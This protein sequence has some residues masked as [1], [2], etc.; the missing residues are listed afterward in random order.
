MRIPI[1]TKLFVSLF[2]TS[3]AL[4]AGMA[5][6]VSYSF[7]SGFQDYLNQQEKK[8]VIE[9]AAT[10]SDYYSKEDGW[11]QLIEHPDIWG[12]FLGD[13][14]GSAPRQPPERHVLNFPQMDSPPRNEEE[15]RFPPPPQTSPVEELGPISHRIHL[16]DAQ[17]Q[18]VIGVP[19]ALDKASFQWLEVPV[20][21]GTETVGWLVLQQRNL[22][23][24]PLVVRFYEQQQS[25]LLW[26]I[27][28]AGLTSLVVALF[29]VRYFL[30]PLKHL[31]EGAS[32]LSNG[33]YDFVFEGKSNDEFA[34]LADSFQLLL[35]SLKKQK[36][37]REQWLVDISHELR[38]P[39]AVLRSELEAIQDGIRQADMQRIDSM[40]HQVMGLRRLVDDLYLLSKT[41]SGVYQMNWQPL[42]LVTL[43]QRLIHQFDARAMEKGLHIELIA[44]SDP[45]I[46]KGDEKTLEQLLVNVLENSLRYT[47]APG[48]IQ[49]SIIDQEENVGVCVEDSL[50]GVAAEHLPNVFRRLYRVDQ[51]R[52]RQHGGSGLGLS[53]CR[54]IV[55]MHG[56]D[57]RARASTLGGLAIDITLKKESGT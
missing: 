33:D 46:L 19:P 48:S 37:S 17:R 45:V 29:L 43:V 53:I 38:T 50:P 40:H 39:I 57:I 56:G 47:D 31:K 54:N 44:S 2:I 18:W 36:E 41:D 7:K 25:N 3:V 22:V 52:S 21:S 5:F 30:S 35:Q 23:T 16:L 4:V 10:L 51:S 1:V 20:I 13:Q 55:T 14:D 6:L 34:A 28:L 12:A 27:G 11:Q 26:I 24:G 8:Q 42:N 15:R 49:V 32:A 9:Y